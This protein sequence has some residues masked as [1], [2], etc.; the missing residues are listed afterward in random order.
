VQHCLVFETAA[1]FCGIA[2]SPAGITRFQL[3]A[4]GAAAA[5]RLL[6]RRVPDAE[7]GPP[8]PAVAEA[9]AAVRRYF[10]GEATDL[11]GIRTTS[12]TERS[13]VAAAT[14][15]AGSSSGSC[16]SRGT[17]Q[18]ASAR[19]SASAMLDSEHETDAADTRAIPRWCGSAQAQSNT[20]GAVSA[21]MQPGTS[22]HDEVDPTSLQERALPTQWLPSS[23]WEY[24][25]HWLSSRLS[26][27]KPS[28]SQRRT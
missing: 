20:V 10:D 21:G 6:R 22:R 28:P 19:P 3:P 14:D 18:P 24:S 12:G 1:G 13:M 17:R 7:P 4:T 25:S 8:P 11:S 9:V 16:T 2:W 27:V 15:C 26:Q 23:H 5:E